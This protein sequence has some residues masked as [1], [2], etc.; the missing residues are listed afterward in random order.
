[1]I[2]VSGAAVANR[3]TQDAVLKIDEAMLALRPGDNFRVEVGRQEPLERGPLPVD[4][5][6]GGPTREAAGRHRAGRPRCA[7]VR[8]P[9]CSSVLM[10]RPWGARVRGR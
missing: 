1:M 2:L 10:G 5:G 9:S 3:A 6:R 8:R 7:M 4:V